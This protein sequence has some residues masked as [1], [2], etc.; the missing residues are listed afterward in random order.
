VT[1]LRDTNVSVSSRAE[2]AAT[3]MELKEKTKD[4]GLR[5]S[6]VSATGL[7]G[8]NGSGR[9]KQTPGKSRTA[10]GAWRRQSC[11][12]QEA[13]S[14]VGSLLHARRLHQFLTGAWQQTLRKWV[15]AAR[16]LSPIYSLAGQIGT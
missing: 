4:K 15:A 11:A 14:Y 5:R 7:R 16:M 9:P 13:K 2:Q 3:L 1:E 12:A 10:A 6:K 8:T